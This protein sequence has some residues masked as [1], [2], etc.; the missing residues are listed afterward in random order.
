MSKW[1]T[2]TYYPYICEDPK[3]GKQVEVPRPTIPIVIVYKDKP[4]WDFQALVDS[5]SD[6]NLFPAEIGETI[7]MDIKSG[8]RRPIRGIGDHDIM[9][10]THK[11]KILA[12]GK[13]FEAEIDF[14]YEQKSPLLGR[15]GFFNFFKEICFNEKVLEITFR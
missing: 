6:R 11:V 7:G 1:F 14:S 2:V 4:S 10:Y 12:A 8:N 9:A 13:T 15:S 3:T 5:G